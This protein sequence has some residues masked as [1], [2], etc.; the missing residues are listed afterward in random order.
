METGARRVF[1]SRRYEPACIA[2][3]ATVQD[4]LRADGVDAETFSAALLH[5][6]WTVRSQSRK[7]FQVFT[8]FWRHC[9]ARPDPPKPLRAPKQIAA[10][11][12]WPKSLELRDLQLEP[13]SG[14]AAGF[15]PAWHPGEAGAG[16]ALKRFLSRAFDD[17]PERRNRPDVVGTS[18]L[19][20]HLHFGEISPRQV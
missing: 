7:P 15:R 13:H 1:W 6:P 20:P 18:R 2:R 10:P 17:Y 9:L 16:A 3:D 11:A 5:E 8:P 19:S 4:V 12:H 14:W